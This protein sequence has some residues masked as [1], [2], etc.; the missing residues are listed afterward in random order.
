MTCITPV[1]I[2][3]DYRKMGQRF[4]NGA[5]PVP[6]GKCPV[7]LRNRQKD[8]MFRL[9]QEQ[10]RSTSSCFV[11]LTYEETPLAEDGKPTLYHRH[12]QHFLKRLRKQNREKIK[13]YCVGEYG[14]QFGRPHYHLILFNLDHR[15]IVKQSAITDIWHAGKNWINGKPGITQTDACTAGSIGY[16]TGYVNKRQHFGRSRND[17]LYPPTKRPEYS[18]MSKGLGENWLTENIINTYRDQVRVSIEL[19]SGEKRR[20]PRYFKDRIYDS[21]ELKK[22]YIEKIDEYLFDEPEADASHYIPAKKNLI[23]TWQH[24]ENLK[25]RNVEH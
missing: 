17:L 5:V 1:T 14:D 18:T 19:G 2:V 7:C 3:R 25:R 4:E 13:Y 10:K 21:Y 6:C 9:T 8:W 16:V 20:I 11:T 12:V 24:R 15:K 22:A 23:K